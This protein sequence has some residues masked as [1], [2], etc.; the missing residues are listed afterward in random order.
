MVCQ[1][2]DSSI[3]LRM[4]TVYDIYDTL[5]AY[6][7]KQHPF[8]AVCTNCILLLFLPNHKQ[9]L[10]VTTLLHLQ[11]KCYTSPRKLSIQLLDF[12]KI[13]SSYSTP[14]IDHVHFHAVVYGNLTPE[15]LLRSELLAKLLC[16]K[17]PYQVHQ[18]LE[19]TSLPVFGV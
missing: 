13:L 3:N 17:H 4:D 14:I 5:L 7:T 9:P 6:P 2:N 1:A 19:S 10:V 18:N 12:A 11:Q 16:P 15:K 8:C